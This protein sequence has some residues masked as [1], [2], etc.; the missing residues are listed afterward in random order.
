MAPGAVQASRPDVP[1]GKIEGGSMH[2][3][4]AAG[5][6]RVTNSPGLRFCAD[7]HGG[8]TQ[9]TL[10]HPHEAAGAARRSPAGRLPI[11]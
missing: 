6:G 10:H 2:Q 3:R 4:R 11:P 7:P 5:I 8:V 9:L 1:E